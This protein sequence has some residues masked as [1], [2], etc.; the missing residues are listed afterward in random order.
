MVYLKIFYMEWVNNM[1]SGY[2]YMRREKIRDVLF[3]NKLYEVTD[4]KELGEMI[5]IIDL[6]DV[7]FEDRQKLELFFLKLRNKIGSY[8]DMLVG[9]MNH[10]DF[11][12]VNVLKN[13]SMLEKCKV[14]KIKSKNVNLREL[15]K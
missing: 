9:L 12:I 13:T 15:F 10:F 8:Y 4:D 14:E 3:L 11:D 2:D 7:G 6:E 1:Y 5:N